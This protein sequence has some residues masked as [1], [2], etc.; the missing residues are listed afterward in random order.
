MERYSMPPFHRRR[1][2]ADT[3]RDDIVHRPGS[4]IGR[5]TRAMEHAEQAASRRDLEQNPDTQE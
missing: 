1:I 3:C 2:V 5:A 4:E